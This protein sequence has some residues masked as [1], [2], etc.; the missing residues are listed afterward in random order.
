M[1]LAQEDEFSPRRI[2]ERSMATFEKFKQWS[3][4]RGLVG[5][6]TDHIIGVDDFGAV[7][8]HKCGLE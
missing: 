3:S 4:K 7:S 2:Q 5:C 6:I 1:L 8:L